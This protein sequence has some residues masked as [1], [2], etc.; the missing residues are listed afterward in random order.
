MPQQTSCH[1]MRIERL[2]KKLAD[3]AAIE[4]RLKRGETPRGT[5][6]FHTDQVSRALYPKFTTKS[7]MKEA[8]NPSDAYAFRILASSGVTASAIEM[9]M[10][11]ESAGIFRKPLLRWKRR[12]ENDP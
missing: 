1:G 8:S 10:K 3:I 6:S 9:L 7:P 2:E 11:V 12:I 5:T 4:E